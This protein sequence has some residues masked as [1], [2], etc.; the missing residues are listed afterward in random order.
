MSVLLS[1][2]ILAHNK[3]DAIARTLASLFAQSAL[4]SVA[5]KGSIEVVVVA[6]GCSDQTEQVARGAVERLATCTAAVSARVE[7]LPIASKTNAWN[8]FVHRLGDQEAEFV[9]IMDADVRLLQPD[10]LDK[11]IGAL[12]ANPEAVLSSPTP[13]KDIV[14]R[15]DRSWRARFSIAMTEISHGRG[16]GFAGCM[17]CM[18]GPAIR[19]IWFP[20]GL[21]GDD[22]VL[23]GLIV[24]NNCR[25]MR[26]EYSKVV[27]V[28]DA[29]VEFETYMRLADVYRCQRRLA[30]IRGMDAILWRYL[31]EHATGGNAGEVIRKLNEHDPRWFLRYVRAQVAA[32]G[33]WVMPRGVLWRRLRWVQRLPWKARVR[34]T[35]WALAAMPIDVVAHLD[36]NWRLKRGRL[37]GVWARRRP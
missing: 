4:Q 5:E 8:E 1:V 28:S 7:T 20:V 2:G 13:V 34:Q 33:W 12:R 32:G 31:W 23:H 15:G 18:R 3:E 6:N 27:G 9:V 24:T 30:V 16:G 19:S 22:A 29:S 10:L 17:Y 37:E 25:H 35:F 26:A 36:A 21:L 14:G 11:L